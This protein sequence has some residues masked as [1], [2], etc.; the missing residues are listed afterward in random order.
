MFKTLLLVL[1]SFA[2]VFAQSAGNSGMAF[3]KM[4][5]GARNIAMGDA[6]AAAANDVTA[7]FYNPARLSDQTGNEILLMHNEW[8]QGV[9][10]EILGIRTSVWSLPLAFGFNV[11]SINDI[12]VRTIASAEPISTFNANYFFG[13]V[14]TGFN[15]YDNL[16]AGLSVR[17]LY[18]GL[19]TDEAAGWGFDFGFNYTTPVN[20]LTA[21][22]VIKN[23]GFM[24]KL[25]NEKTKLPS[26]FRIGPA[27][28]FNLLNDKFSITTAAEFQKYLPTND[29]HFNLGVELLYD[30]LIALRGGYQSGYDTKSFTGGFGLYWG[31]FGFDY[32]FQPFSLGLGDAN[33]FSIRFKF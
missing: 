8:I 2:A 12:Q 33:M 25:K 9:K 14:S 21:S 4:G 13:S 15:V 26:E 11:T 23:L 32:A 7:L 17:Y 27:Y 29:S 22:A 3:L 18:E 28:S 31:N 19:Y 30:K 1:V 24:S 16:S 20:G 10:S 6:G 5:F